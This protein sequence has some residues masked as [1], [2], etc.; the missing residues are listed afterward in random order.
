MSNK[1]IFITLLRHCQGNK[2]KY[3]R[4]LDKKQLNCKIFTDS[5]GRVRRVKQNVRLTRIHRYKKK[6]KETEQ[7]SGDSAYTFAVGEV[8][9]EARRLM[10][11]TKEALYKGTAQAKAGNRVGDVSAAVQERQTHSVSYPAIENTS[12]HVVS[13]ELH[14]NQSMYPD[15][16]Q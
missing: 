4:K 16:H 6:C 7:L 15:P 11:V 3:R 8:A 12:L 2:W 5:S 13:S 1:H 9:P 14:S 10:E